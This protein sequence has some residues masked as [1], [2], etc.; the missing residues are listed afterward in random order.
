MLKQ[1][2]H[3]P[4]HKRSMKNSTEDRRLNGIALWMPAKPVDCLPAKLMVVNLVNFIKPNLTS[5]EK[6]VFSLNPFTFIS[7]F[8]CKVT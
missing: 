7:Y 6:C 1:P 3:R 4:I 2:L 5:S 8:S